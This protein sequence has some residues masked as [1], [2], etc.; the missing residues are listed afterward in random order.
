MIELAQL[1]TA[2]VPCN[3]CYECCRNQIV[4]ACE[5]FG[6]D[7]SILKDH[8]DRVQEG[9]LTVYRLHKK[10][11]GDCVFLDRAS[12]CT[13]YD[14][15]P[16]LCRAYD[17][18]A[19]LQAMKK[20]GCDAKTLPGPIRKAARRLMTAGYKPGKIGADL[21]MLAGVSHLRIDP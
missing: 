13:I 16:T 1:A 19:Q 14:Q 3:G 8:A 5:H 6:D 10:P 15:R 9:G 21:G 11:N 12:G 7:V 17:C 4:A 20:T 18:V 2:H